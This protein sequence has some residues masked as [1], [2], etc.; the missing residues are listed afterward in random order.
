MLAGHS[1][2][3]L[4][5]LTFAARYP[6]EVAGMVLLDSTAPAT[7]TKPRAASPSDGGSYDVISRVSA[8]VSTSARLGLG[9]VYAQLASGS[10]PPQSQDEVDASTATARN[11][12]STID[13]YVQA[14]TSMEEAAS[15]DDFAD[16]PLV[17]LTAGSGSDAAHLASQNEL[18]TLSTNS[19][20]RVIEGAVHEALVA[21]QEG[22]ATSTQ[23]ILDVVSSVRS[24]GPLSR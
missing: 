15:L 13:E 24:G 20:H 16:K 19:V 4:Y 7:A 9:R 12:R 3:G 11:L 5:A 17:V 6:D 21:D 2:G 1:F 18:A 8:V 22:A 14:N 23:A 10:L